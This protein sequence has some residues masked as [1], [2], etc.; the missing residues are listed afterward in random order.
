[1]NHLSSKN[2]K[3]GN[4]F[5]KLGY[6]KKMFKGR[7]KINFPCKVSLL[8]NNT[9]NSLLKDY[10]LGL[11]NGSC[12]EVVV[13]EESLINA[14]KEYVEYSPLNTTQFLSAEHY[15]T[16]QLEI[17]FK[18]KEEKTEIINLKFCNTTGFE[19]DD[20]DMPAGGTMIGI[21]T[22]NDFDL[23][24][25]TNSDIDLEDLQNTSISTDNSNI[26]F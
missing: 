1:M 23:N 22:L 2:K 4:S 25:T 11:R 20:L 14:V 15:K 8:R 3:Y 7:S 16:R 17:D 13:E 18:E 24:F 5:K 12:K 26:N 21:N 6:K 9:C 19:E 10:N